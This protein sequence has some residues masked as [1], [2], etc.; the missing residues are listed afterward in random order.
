MYGPFRKLISVGKRQLLLFGGKIK[1]ARFVVNDL[2]SLYYSIY[3][4]KKWS[5]SYL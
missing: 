3:L 5:R 1:K 2:C 4:Y